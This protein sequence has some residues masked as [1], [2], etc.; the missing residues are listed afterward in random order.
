M[1]SGYGSFAQR[2]PRKLA[3]VEKSRTK[4]IKKTKTFYTCTFVN[5]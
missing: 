4:G 1:A 2:E 5:Y 3:V